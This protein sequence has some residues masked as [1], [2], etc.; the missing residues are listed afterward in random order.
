MNRPKFCVGEEVITRGLHFNEYDLDRIE[1]T[2][3]KLVS[4]FRIII[5]AAN[6]VVFHTGWIYQTA[7]VPENFWWREKRLKKLPPKT[8]AF[9]D[10][11]EGLETSNPELLETQE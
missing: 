10:M 5:R 8:N 11:M 4:D 6:Q 7:N 9:E 2:K 1:I 3:S